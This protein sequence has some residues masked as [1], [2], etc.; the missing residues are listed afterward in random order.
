MLDWRHRIIGNRRIETN[1]YS[2]L[3][4][5]HFLTATPLQ[6]RKCHLNCKRITLIHFVSRALAQESQFNFST[7]YSTVYMHAPTH[8]P[9]AMANWRRIHQDN[10]LGPWLHFCEHAHELKN[11]LVLVQRSN[12]V[13][14]PS[15]HQSWSHNDLAQSY[16][17]TAKATLQFISC[18]TNNALGLCAYIEFSPAQPKTT[19]T[20]SAI[21]LL[22]IITIV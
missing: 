16:S 12:D 20:T 10:F 18:A 1:N 8:F 7:K 17:A 6:N 9:P 11:S 14:A 13:T 19:F 4:G 22:C 15:L 5:G 21:L 2:P 3:V